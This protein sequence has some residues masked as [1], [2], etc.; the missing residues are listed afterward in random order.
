MKRI[1]LCGI[2]ARFSHSNLA[3]LCLKQSTDY[4]EHIELVEMTINDRP[5]AIVERIVNTNPDAVGFSCYIWNI[6]WILRVASSV[7]K[8]LPQCFIFFGGPEVSSNSDDLMHQYPFVDMIIKGS[9]EEP[10]KHFTKYFFEEKA[11]LNTPSSIIRD[12]DKL[13][14]NDDIAPAPMDDV[15]FLYD[16]LNPYQN[17]VIYYETSRGCPYRCAYCMSAKEKLRYLSLDRV[18]NEL[19]FFMRSNVKQV[20]LV[21]R[22][23]NYPSLRAHAIL[24]MLVELSE[25]YPEST[26]N[27]HFEVSACLLTD[28]I[29]AL[30]RSARKD[31]MKFEIGI[32]STH[33]ETLDAINRKHDVKK[34]F[35]NTKAL[36][37]MDN[38][39]VHVDLIAGLPHES[40]DTFAKSFDD[41]YALGANE[42]QLGFL[43]V[44]KGSPMASLAE[45]YEIAY[46]DYPPYE[47]L[48][49]HVLSYQDISR[50][51][52]IEELVDGMVNTGHFKHALL[53]LVPS[54]ASP[55]RFFEQFSDHLDTLGY[56]DRPQK[57][58]T[59]FALLYA[60]VKNLP[61]VDTLA[62][63]D[64]LTLDWY[65]LEKPRRFPKGLEVKLEYD[66]QKHIRDFYKD[67][68]RVAR[69]L[70]MYQHLSGSDIS[71]RCAMVFLQHLYEEPTMILFNYGLK[72]DDSGFMQIIDPT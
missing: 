33:P 43:K 10:F 21:D 63:K 40:Y 65:R 4:G 32:Q 2:N 49:T 68:D 38:V 30:I 48:S 12:D 51:H 44:L 9:G 66:Q 47:V 28:D 8:I 29:L 42:V 19:D 26:T 36:C 20:K 72:R 24:K 46:T 56:F 39:H 55:F 13:I 5:P 59:L 11:I 50:L 62:I 70:P 57:K 45:K 18:R 60:Y 67:K 31:L 52:R 22:T 17:K 1:T 3:L 16:D 14:I 53:Y 23:F 58:Q 6:E 25:Q 61:N 35:E 27:F 15:P 71:K 69:Y 7:K 41:T 54:Y 37:D 34:L 64:A